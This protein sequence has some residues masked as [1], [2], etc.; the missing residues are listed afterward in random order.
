MAECQSEHS[1]KKLG[2]PVFMY[3]DNIGWVWTKIQL[4][5][6]RKSVIIK[7]LP[8]ENG[9]PKSKAEMR[10]IGY[11]DEQTDCIA[12]GIPLNAARFPA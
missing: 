6:Y 8:K 7:V 9:R 1:R 4:P 2:Y 5:F 12:Q 10:A 11:A 3:T